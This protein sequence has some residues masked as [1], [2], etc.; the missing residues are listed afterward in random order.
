MRKNYKITLLSAALAVS[1]A[2][3]GCVIISP[4]SSGKTEK[5]NNANDFENL[6]APNSS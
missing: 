6:K 3:L 2:V 4:K 5:G 1:V